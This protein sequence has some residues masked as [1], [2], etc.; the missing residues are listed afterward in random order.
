[1]IFASEIGIAKLKGSTTDTVAPEIST[2][3]IPK[4]EFVLSPALSIA[5]EFLLV[6]HWPISVRLRFAI[7]CGLRCSI[8]EVR[9]LNLGSRRLLYANLFESQI[10]RDLDVERCELLCAA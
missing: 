9:A 4:I 6:T 1:V 5:I 2:R 3:H 8:F 7:R 10:S